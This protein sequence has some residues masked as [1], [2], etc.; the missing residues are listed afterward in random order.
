MYKALLV[1]AS[2]SALAFSQ[3]SAPIH[4]GVTNPPS[5][6]TRTFYASD[7]NN[8]KTWPATDGNGNT[9]KLSGIRLW[10]DSVKWGQVNPSFGVYDW[11]ELDGWIS[12]A[13]SAGL[14]V[15]YTF[16]DT[17]AYAT[18]IPLGNGCAAPGPYSCGVPKDVNA[19]GTGTDNYFKT[20]VTAV[21][22]RYKGRIAY[23]EFWN[24]HDAHEF[25]AGNETQ[26]VRMCKDAS[27][28]VRSI[29]PSAHILSP[30]VHGPT[31][32]TT[33][34][35]FIQGGGGSTFDYVN[36][37]MRGQGNGNAIPE[38]FLTMYADTTAEMKK[39]GI[40][41]PITDGEW[42]ILVNQLTDA[43]MLESFWSRSLIL[44][45]SV[46]LFR[47]YQYQ[48]DSKSPYGLQG[49]VSGTAWN[50]VASWMTSKSVSPCLTSAGIYSCNIGSGVA[51]WNSLL[52][53][54]NGKCSTK[55]Y[56]VK[57]GAKT[58]STIDG[59]TTAISEKTIQLGVKPVYVN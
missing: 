38:S 45:A 26:M 6:I 58:Y 9:A 19:D 21:V 10:D 44:R 31:M 29:D 57:Q 25:W 55:P 49:S 47:Q 16:G 46:G 51:V 28:I 23:Y 30:S 40:A 34:D 27:A 5:P 53:C 50:V 17:P 43:D 15:L 41:K 56:T 42:G 20:Y 13:Q 32:A 35:A 8:G 37:H 18:T 3:V 52:T 1:V 22:T 48:W 54:E 33:F 36:V 14:D 24:E 12:K 4:I 7:F 59:K 11:S 2:F 39:R